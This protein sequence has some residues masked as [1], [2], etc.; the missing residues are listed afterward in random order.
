MPPGVRRCRRNRRGRRPGRV[1]RRPTRPPSHRPFAPGPARTFVLVAAKWVERYLAQSKLT[2]S[3]ISVMAPA[4]VGWRHTRL[5][6]SAQFRLRNMGSCPISP[7]CPLALGCQTVV[8]WLLPSNHQE[9]CNTVLAG[10]VRLL[11]GMQSTGGG[12]STCFLVGTR[13][14]TWNVTFNGSCQTAINGNADGKSACAAVGWEA[15]PSSATGSKLFKTVHCTGVV[16]DAPDAVGNTLT[17]RDGGPGT[18]FAC[19]TK[20]TIP[21]SGSIMLA[22]IDVEEKNK[23]CCL[24][25]VITQ[26]DVTD[27]SYVSGP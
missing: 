18:G 6:R 24:L 15:I 27:V 17:V 3:V 1:G 19:T 20:V 2:R 23:S 8:Q 5:F 21:A 9:Y 4:R 25:T 26:I 7:G 10:T 12:S 11:D 22:S 16:S 14:T 13:G